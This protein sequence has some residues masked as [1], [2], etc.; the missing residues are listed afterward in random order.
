MVDDLF[1][2]RNFFLKATSMNLIRIHFLPGTA[3]KGSTTKDFVVLRPKFVEPTLSAIVGNG[4]DLTIFSLDC[5]SFQ[6]LMG[7]QIP[8]IITTLIT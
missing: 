7:F 4:Y 6:K 1:D 3:S 2:K 5:V 8:D